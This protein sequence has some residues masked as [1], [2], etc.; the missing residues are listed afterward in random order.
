MIDF[1]KELANFIFTSKYARYDEI[2]KR[3][4]TWEETTN[5]VLQMHLK[6]AK[7]LGVEGKNLEEIEWAFQMVKDRRVVPS[8]RSMQFAGKAIE[9]HNARIFNCF[10]NETEFIT[11]VGVKRFS[12]FKD[13]DQIIVLTHLGNWKQ[14]VVKC[15]GKQKLNEIKITRVKANYSVH[16][17]NDHRW[18]LKN[19]KETTKLKVSDLLLG[20]KDIF[21]EFDYDTASPLE[22]LYWSYGYVYGDGTLLK[23]L[24]TGKP[25]YSMV[26]LCG[27]EIKYKD[28][29]EELGFKTSTSLSLNGDF[30]AYTGKYL[31][32]SPDPT[33]D[34]P[35]HIRAFVRGYLDAD[36]TKIKSI[37]L[38]NKFS[39][40]QT[41]NC[42][43]SK[44]IEK[45]FPIAGIYINSKKDISHEI[46]NYG[47]RGP[48]CVKY[49]I[50][51]TPNNKINSN[52]PFRVNSIKSTNRYE[53]VWCLEVEDDKSF[54]FPNGLTTGNCA[55]RHVDSIRSFAEIFYLLLC[56]CGVGIGLKKFFLNRLPN[57]VDAND[58]SG[59][60]IT[61]VVEDNIEGWAD[62]TEALLN[63]YF[64]NTAYSGRKIIFD[65][66]RIRK[67]G[68]PLKTGGGKAP[69]YEGLKQ[70]HRKIKDLLDYVIDENHQTR[71]KSINVYDILMHCADAVLSGG[72][73][74][75][76]T[77]IIFDKDDDDMLN[78]KTFFTVDKK[79]RFSFDETEKMYYGKVKVNKKSFEIELN[80][81]E[82]KQLKEKNI[83][84]W[85]HIEPQRA[86]SNNSVLLLKDELLKEEFTRIIEK[87]KQFGEPGFILG[88]HVDQLFNPCMEISMIPV[89]KDGVCGVQFCNLSSINGKK[90][91]TATDFKEAV[92]AATI[93]GTLQASFTDFKYLSHI[94]KQLTEEEALLGVSITGIMDIPKILLDSDQQILRARETIKTNKR[95][96]K[97]LGINQ[98]ARIT[99]IKPEGT[100]SL[101]LC[102]SSG[103]HCHHA[104][105]YF[106]LVQCNQLE[107]PYNYLKKHNPNMCEPSVWSATK[108]DDVVCFPIDAGEGSMVKSDLTAL[109]HLRIIKNTQEDW[110][111]NGITSSNKK[112]I[113]HNVSCTVIVKDDEWERVISYVFKNKEYFS[114]VSFISHTGD[115]DYK[116]APLQ[117]ITKE[118]EEKWNK[119]VD[120]YVPIDFSKMKETEDQ[121]NLAYELSCAGG[122]CEIPSL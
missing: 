116:Q 120:N 92:K 82:Y 1:K 119:I 60:I 118:D 21:S 85:T 47:P 61:Y 19:G 80:E 86:R 11:S 71:L 56:G 49:S 48:F 15:Y 55:V 59:T 24:K 2:K 75:A 36:G 83:V 5:R 117:T 81:F 12:D 115:K 102:S 106:R 79:H 76:A 93:I 50:F 44:F 90:V 10:G 46:T 104:K 14:A 28:R 17:T 91:K 89:T 87:T 38:K 66:S 68:I 97:I 8:M 63:C 53:N 30:M 34:S 95:W 43:H 45:C 25:T 9:A 29:F 67:K 108:T 4:E 111:M 65:Y 107:N 26:R 3:R 57:L 100:T 78:A 22:R 13:G 103:I 52:T 39:S 121:T 32:E 74:R 64:K 84:T 101:V 122:S 35:E 58:K 99:C 6:K 114:A 98:A 69:G 23:N 70:S 41:S 72:I 7:I 31:K 18:L 33:I 40:I 16:S 37:K 27:D 94:T 77:S 112:P 109:Q 54:V 62:S 110:V 20:S 88:T 73:R 51:N 96:A 105:K 42:E 113:N